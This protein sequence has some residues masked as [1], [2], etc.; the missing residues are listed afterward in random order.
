MFVPELYAVALF[1]LI[2]PC[3]AGEAGQ[4]LQKQPRVRFE[5]FYWTTSGALCSLS[6]SWASPSG[7]PIHLSPDSFINNLC[8]ADGRHIFFAFLGGAIWNVAISFW[9]R[10]LHRRDAVAFPVGSGWPS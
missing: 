6:L 1:M 2:V 3:L 5:L 7:E 10:P 4:L 8:S 9:W